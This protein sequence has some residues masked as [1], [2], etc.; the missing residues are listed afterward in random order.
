[1]TLQRAGSAPDTPPPP[2]RKMRYRTHTIED[3]VADE[4]WWRDVLQRAILLSFAVLDDQQG[5]IIRY[6]MLG[7]NN[8]QI[9]PLVGISNEAVRQKKMRAW[10]RLRAY[11][12]E[13]EP[14]TD[15][16]W[17]RLSQVNKY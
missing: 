13:L 2:V 7:L 17:A 11:L 6:A 10:E 1:M 15:I 5:T 16:E 3:A 4:D 8:H 12:P 14:Y 9:A